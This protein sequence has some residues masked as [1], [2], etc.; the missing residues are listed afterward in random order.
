MHF[1]EYFLR[2][3]AFEH[4][5]PIPMQSMLLPPTQPIRHS[6]EGATFASHHVS[7]FD[8]IHNMFSFPHSPP[9]LIQNNP[10]RH[11]Y[12]IRPPHS[13]RHR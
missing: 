6:G 5:T 12:L 13:F 7:F 8:N 11:T 4:R 2:T 9:S 1:C 3:N 10:T